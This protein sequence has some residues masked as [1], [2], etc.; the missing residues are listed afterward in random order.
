MKLS[1]SISLIIGAILI[2]ASPLFAQENPEAD[3]LLTLLETAEGEVQL[4]I[5]FT[6]SEITTEPIDD[7]LDFA[8][9]AIDLASDLSSTE[10]LVE[11]YL[12]HGYILYQVDEY[13][14]AIESFD[15]AYEISEEAGYS[16]GM[17]NALLR[18]GKAYMYAGNSENAT[19]YYNQALEIS[20]AEKIQE[21][22]AK[23]LYYIADINR[24]EGKYGTAIE[25]YQL[26]REIAIK[27]GNLPLLADITGDV[28]LIAY[29]Q[30]NYPGAI[31][32]YEES[33]DLYTQAGQRFDAG[34]IYLRL[35]NASLEVGEYDVA[36]DYLQKALP[37]FEEFNSYRGIAAV[38]N[39][40]GVIY[41]T[42]ELYE[43]ALEVDFD[44]LEKSRQIGDQREIANALNNIGNVYN[45]LAEDSLK[46]LFGGNFQDS[47]KIEPTNKYLDL[48]DEALKY[49]NEAISAREKLED[50]QGL[51]SPIMNIGIIYIN[52]GKPVMAL[53]PL[54]RALELNK[55]I[56][57]KASQ[58]TIYLLL[59]EVYLSFENYNTSLD[60]LD[61][62]LELA[63]E[64]DI[65][66]IVMKIYEKLSEIYQKRNN[67]TQSLKYYKLYFSCFEEFNR[68]KRQKSIAD[69]QVKYET[70]ATEKENALLQAESELADTKL[71]QT[72]I[73]LFI[74]I[75]AI[76]V[77]IAMML[78][79]IRQNNLKKKANR[80]LAQKNSLITEQKKEITDSI[81]YASRIQ[82]AM[83]PP[84]DYVDNLMPER[85]ILYM[86]RDIVSG[87]YYYINEK[88]GKVICV[89]ADC[90]GHGVPGAFM[91]ML[92]IAFL[93]EIISK[94]IELHTDQI[95]GELRNHV[96]TSLHQTGKEGES[97]DGM[98]LAIYILDKKTNKIEFSGANNSLLIYRNGEM[99]E[100][101][102]DKMPIGIHTRHKKPF[103]RHSLDL[104]KGDMIYT[105]S[106]GYPDQFGGPKQKKFMIRNFKKMLL[107]IHKKSMDEQLQIMEKTLSDWM[108]E[109]EQVDDILVI[110]VRI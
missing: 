24:E 98:D 43:K 57:D 81:Q 61:N 63:L 101:K 1:R 4:Q 7:R 23:A 53:A 10:L 8:E 59:G 99:I 109:T 25:Y 40:M 110:G 103:T 80:E 37:I 36:L 9:D 62:A 67:Y 22:E 20:R 42:Q 54:E 11:A 38:T 19:N 44:H 6:L 70:E 14:N 74:T 97:Q 16:Y 91:S 41:F 17:T 32:N 13:D 71:K 47:V 82:T 31:M 107:D 12:N 88:D 78:Q 28:G 93:N 83:L 27:T 18:I 52:S 64:T 90:T 95:L 104:Q 100:A 2:F 51:I 86:P 105:F 108:V 68:E 48:F 75:L 77:F 102:A 65:K 69:M 79:L 21:N 96:I 58:A 49:Y 60:Y 15:R 73:I 35:G 26:A 29:V 87:D 72:R 94:N 5:L 89:A 92:G 66:E 39:S 56:N 50:Q 45:K 55:E 33:A 34:R 46:F 84:G 3:S 106:D 76:G 30:G 85:F